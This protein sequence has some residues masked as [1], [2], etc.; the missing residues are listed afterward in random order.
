MTDK[1]RSKRNPTPSRPADLNLPGFHTGWCA[2]V[3]L[4]PDLGATSSHTRH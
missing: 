3:R 1:H 2:P 4:T